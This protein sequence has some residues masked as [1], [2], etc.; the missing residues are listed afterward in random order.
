MKIHLN[1]KIE[2]TFEDFCTIYQDSVK[3]LPEAKRKG[4]LKAQYSIYE[5]ERKAAGF[6][7]VVKKTKP[8]GK[9]EN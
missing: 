7:K 9:K 6:D 5:A 1:P 2:M 4:F 3:G 8:K